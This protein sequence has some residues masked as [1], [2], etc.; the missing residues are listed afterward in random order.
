MMKKTIET[1]PSMSLSEALSLTSEAR[2]VTTATPP[3]RIVHTNAAWAAITGYRFHEVAD[4]TCAFLRPPGHGPSEDPG[5]KK[6]HE[7]LA[8]Q[9][10][11]D[12]ELVNYDRDG[13]PFRNRISIQLVTG[14]THFVGTLQ[15]SPIEDGSVPPLVRDTP[16]PAR[17][18]LMA[19]NYADPEIYEPAAKRVAR[20]G[21]GADSKRRLR[22]VLA[23]TVD[24]IVLCDRH[25]PHQIIHP[26]QPWLEMCGY[27]LEE[28]EGLT[29]KILTGPETDGD[30]IADLLRCVRNEEPSVQTVVNYKRGGLRFL[31]QVKTLPV[32]DE[33]DELAAF[34][35]MLHEVSEPV[36]ERSRVIGS[37]NPSD[38][39]KWDSLQ[40]R[41]TANAASMSDAS[42][43]ASQHPVAAR[44]EAASR[45][46]GNHDAVL[47][48]AVDA[49]PSPSQPQLH[50]LDPIFMPYYDQSMR[51]VAKRLLGRAAH[52]LGDE[53]LEGTHPLFREQQAAWGRVATYL[54]SRLQTLPHPSG[55]AP[56]MSKAAGAAMLAVLREAVQEA[57][58]AQ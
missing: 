52:G 24:P 34:M 32:Y 38:T 37:L 30:A 4:K 19:T 27:T 5:V 15:A 12:T 47:R 2:V 57:G 43:T 45:L 7:A 6:L 8:K 31:N 54:T 23:N 55:R 50:R 11:I 39:P 48:D 25:F 51:D 44:R 40:H 20:G 28:V 13:K 46:I 41:L 9:R 22:D 14:G 16:A 53:R 3:Y 42:G 18:P 26:N 29:N 10:P 58:Q 36:V 49:L 33:N 56:D 1:M 21:R 35:S 17:A